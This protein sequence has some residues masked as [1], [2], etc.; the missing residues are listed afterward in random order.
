[1]KK[2]F[3]YEILISYLRLNDELSQVFDGRMALKTVYVLV[4]GFEVD[5]S[6]LNFQSYW[7]NQKNFQIP[8]ALGAHRLGPVPVVI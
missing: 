8:S 4:A 1:M 5:E 7:K 3:V 6:R 2:T